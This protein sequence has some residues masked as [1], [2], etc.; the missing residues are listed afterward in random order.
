MHLQEPAM[1]QMNADLACLQ[2]ERR[3]L[4]K[5]AWDKGNSLRL[6]RERAWRVA[7]IAFCHVPTAGEAIA[8]SLL[9]KYGECI[10]MNIAACTFQIEK[11]FLEMAVDKLA[12][13][14]DWTTDT[15]RGELAEAKRLVEEVRLLSWVQSQ[16]CT[17][18]VS[19]PPQ[20]VW[21]KRCFL[22][23]E[24]SSEPDSRASSHRPARSAGA[25]KWVQR[26]RRRWGLVMGR[27]PAKDML[28]VE[29][30]RSKVLCRFFK[31]M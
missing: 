2:A 22:S 14:L 25:R 4:Q 11:R 7:T 5:Q 10:G 29:T 18:G 31:N 21:E 1:E 26:F 8:T 6:R 27:L 9:R 30:M 28:T 16:N 3:H 13:V 17:Q 12:L 19:P 15:P 20:F 23:I 24:N